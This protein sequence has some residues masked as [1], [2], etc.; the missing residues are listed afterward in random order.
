MK[1]SKGER[2]DLPVSQ[3]RKDAP[4]LWRNI[5]GWMGLT[6]L[7]L[8]RVNPTWLAMANPSLTHPDDCGNS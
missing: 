6:L 4:L 5:I 7:W 3:P 2:D 1:D 8:A